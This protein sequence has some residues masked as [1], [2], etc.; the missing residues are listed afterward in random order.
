MPSDTVFAKA[1]AFN[2]DVIVA[3]Y[4]DQGHIPVKCMGFVWDT[5]SKHVSVQGV[6][7]TYGIPII[8]TSVDHGVA[9]G[10]A[11]NG[12][13]SMDSLADALDMAV[14]LALGRLQAGKG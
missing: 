7:L 14:Q 3:M 11:G 13:A 6:N 10:K 1:A 8:R 2:Y 9:F 4:H 12:T 5:A